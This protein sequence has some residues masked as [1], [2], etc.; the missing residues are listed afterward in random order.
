M[1]IPP[2]GFEIIG[3]NAICACQAMKLGDRVLSVQ[4]HP[5]FNKEI[6]EFLL[7]N[8]YSKGLFERE[9]L[10]E[11]F[12]KASDEHDGIKVGEGILNFILEVES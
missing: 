9:V 7:E 5:E 3:S 4:G 6:V 12:P 8:R 1:A 11:A 2:E 10:D